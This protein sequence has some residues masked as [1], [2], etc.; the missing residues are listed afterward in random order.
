M[1]VDDQEGALVV[2]EVDGETLILDTEK[3]LVHQLNRTA[4][5]V[6][7][8]E[9][10]GLEPETMAAAFAQDF[11]VDELHAL[12]DVRAALQKLESLSLLS[13][14]GREGDTP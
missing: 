14:R 5:L 8:M 9:R 7:R 2:R 10:E 3:N 12:E 6:W 13:T 1:T 4:S 11:E